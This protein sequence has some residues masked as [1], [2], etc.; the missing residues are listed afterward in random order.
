MPSLQIPLFPLGTLLF[1]GGLLALRIF[2]ARY[3]DMV[4]AC[5]RNDSSFGVVLIREGREVGNA[6][7]THS[8]GTRASIVNWDMQP[9]ELLHVDV[10]GHEKFRVLDTRVQ[11]DQLLTGEVEILAAEPEQA[12]PAQYDYMAKVLRELLPKVNPLYQSREL[13]LEDAAW[14]GGRFTELLPLASS[15]KQWL[16]EL[17]DPG[18][19]LRQLDRSYLALQRE[20]AARD[21]A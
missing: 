2:E 17:D 1:P 4:R 6:A 10:Q 13:A 18:E 20:Q 5:M 8:V 14:V 21:D 15:D 9:G 7:R 12:L 19:R 3:L 11:P 16:L